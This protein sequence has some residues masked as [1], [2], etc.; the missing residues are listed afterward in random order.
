MSIAGGVSWEE[1]V[2]TLKEISGWWRLGSKLPRACQGTTGICTSQGCV[3]LSRIALP[4]KFVTADSK[5]CRTTCI[6]LNKSI[7]FYKSLPGTHAGT[8]THTLW[9]KMVLDNSDEFLFSLLLC[10]V[11]AHGQKRRACRNTKPKPTVELQ[12]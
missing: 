5:T 8:H 12:Q 3:L 1:P 4:I 10:F 9:F 6:Y 7:W 2:S 11:K